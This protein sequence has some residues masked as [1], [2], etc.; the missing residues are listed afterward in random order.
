MSSTTLA[1][2]WNF[3][4]KVLN[5]TFGSEVGSTES[6][7]VWPKYLDKKPA[8]DLYF[9]VQ[10]IVPVGNFEPKAPGQNAGLG[11][12]GQGFS[13]RVEIKTFAKRIEIP[14]EVIRFTKYKKETVEGVKE[15]G[16]AAKRSME[17]QAVAV[18]NNAFSS[19]YTGADGKALCASDH[20]LKGGGT[21]SNAP[22]AL[23][24]SNTALRT[25]LTACRK[26]AGSNGLLAGV[27]GKR[28]IVP[29]DLIWR[30]HEILKSAMKDDTSN[31]TINVMKGKL[32]PVDV[33]WMSSTTN[34][35]IKTD[36]PQ[37]LMRFI[38]DEPEFRQSNNDTALVKEFMGFYR[39]QDTW[40]NPRGVLGSNI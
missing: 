30:A 5:G 23:T 36:A 1:T 24:L 31:H 34:W 38:S 12:F 9:D 11:H 6:E 22:A 3:F 2:Q 39:L 25:Y 29:S 14:E 10:E 40:A 19:S 37:G 28:L 18:L 21:Y 4:K 17:Y 32:E 26:M 7:K 33:P 27:E 20:P 15:L 13:T 16:R 8:D 35:F